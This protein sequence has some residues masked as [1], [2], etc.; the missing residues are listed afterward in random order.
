MLRYE[1]SRDVT[2]ELQ[3]TTIVART[4]VMWLHQMPWFELFRGFWLYCSHF[5]KWKLYG[6]RN[7]R[8]LM[9]MMDIEG[10]LSGKYDNR[11]TSRSH[12]RPRAKPTNIFVG[13]LILSLCATENGRQKWTI[14]AVAGS[15]ILQ[16]TRSNVREQIHV[17]CHTGLIQHVNCV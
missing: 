7:H 2:T 6:S 4:W 11:V 12:D 10:F 13:T 3:E 1:T 16:G 8:F 9:A 5:L 14:R 15:K 17:P